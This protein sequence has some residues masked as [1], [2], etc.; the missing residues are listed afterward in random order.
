MVREQQVLDFV[1]RIYDAALDASHWPAVLQDLVRLSHSNTGNLTA[2]H[3]ANG[4]TTP[5]A[6]VD[7][8]RKGCS[9]F[10]TYYSQ[11]DAAD[12]EDCPD[13]VKTG[14]SENGHQPPG[15]TRSAGAAVRR[16][17]EGQ[18]DNHM[19]ERRHHPNVG[20]RFRH[21]VKQCAGRSERP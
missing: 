15:A 12:D 18:R 5:I 2:L 17:H 8:P 9:D 19:N 4:A 11:A 7:M 16:S 6:G 10:E 14:V 21:A 20:C 13:T 3:L 1:G